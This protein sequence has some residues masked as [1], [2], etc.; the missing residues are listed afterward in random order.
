MPAL[1]GQ[2]IYRKSDDAN[3][4]DERCNAVKDDNLAPLAIG[5]L[6]IRSLECHAKREGKINKIPIIR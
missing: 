5:Y 6:H 1:A 3:V 2:D 4:E